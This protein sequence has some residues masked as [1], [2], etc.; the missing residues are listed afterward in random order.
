M[1]IHESVNR[2]YANQQ[3]GVEILTPALCYPIQKVMEHAETPAMLIVKL[4]VVKSF[5]NRYGFC[6]NHR[7]IYHMPFRF[8]PCGCPRFKEFIPNAGSFLALPPR[9]RL[10][11]LVSA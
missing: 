9:E 5:A 3:E 4:D 2:W 1:E 8:L 10:L 6:Q 11:K 7:R